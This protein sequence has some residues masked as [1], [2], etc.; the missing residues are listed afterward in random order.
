L[1][2]KLLSSAIANK[3]GWSNCPAEGVGAGE[4]EKERSSQEKHKAKTKTNFWGGRQDGGGILNLI[5]AVVRAWEVAPL[6]TG[7]RS[8][9]SRREMEI[10]GKKNSERVGPWGDKKLNFVILTGISA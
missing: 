1:G 7:S 5:C 3:K 8:K 6:Q 2:K 4:A 9:I 10:P